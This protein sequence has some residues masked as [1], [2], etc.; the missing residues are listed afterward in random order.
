MPVPR[1]LVLIA[2]LLCA[3]ALAEAL[4]DDLRAEWVRD[5]QDRLA[6]RGLGAATSRGGAEDEAI[7]ELACEARE[8]ARQ[9]LRA[10]ADAGAEADRVAQ[11]AGAL[12]GAPPSDPTAAYLEART[13]LRRAVF[14]HPLLRSLPGLVFV[15][16]EPGALAHMCDQFYG[17]FASGG[18]GLYVLGDP[19]SPHVRDVVGGQLPDGAFLS[20][21]LSYDGRTIAFAFAEVD[22]WR[23]PRFEADARWTYHLWRIATDGADLTRLTEGPYDD[24]DPCWLPDGGLAFISTRRGGYCRC[25][26]RPVPTYTLHRMA[27]DGTGIAALSAHETN[28]WHPAVAADGTLVYTRWDYVDRHTNLAHSLWRCNTDGTGVAALFGNYNAD[29]KPW[30]IWHAQPI[31]GGHEWVGVAGAHHGYAFGSL[32]RIDP[33]EGSDGLGALTRLTP[34]TAFPEA[35]GYPDEA[36]TTPWPLSRELTLASYS[37]R[38]STQTAAHSVSQGIYALLALPDGTSVRELIYRDPAHSSV[39]ALPL[40]PRPT[41]PA[42]PSTAP[43]SPTGRVVLLDARRSA[44]ALPEV[45]PVSLR[46]VQVLP[47]TTVVADDPPI[48]VAKQV[49]ARLLLG[50]VPIEADGSAQFEVPAGVPVYFQTV[51]PDGMAIQT[52]R[53]LTYLEPGEVRTCIGCHEPRETAPPVAS[54]ATALGRGPSPLASGPEGSRP[55]SYPRLVQPVLDRKCLTCHSGAEPAGGVVLTGD[56]ADGDAWSRSYRAL[57]RKSLVH[58]FDSVNGGEWIPRTTAG[59]FGARASR[60]SA[61]LREGHGGV[62]LEG[63]EWERVALWLDLN[64]PFY[65]SYLPRHVE[66]QRAGGAVPEEEL[67]P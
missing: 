26:A 22:P 48:S 46:V 58:W 28:E 30:G 12:R 39:S 42:R 17:G 51:G 66:I 57:A 55:F 7:R 18:G 56:H 52:M 45:A 49:S 60:L 6:E 63:E 25:G 67:L 9:A 47:K 62:V 24:F 16:A 38:W 40:R 41:P 15:K 34:E 31:P 65:G 43:A 23:A 33:W 3:P 21:D 35:E 13:L 50:S 61:L 4:R 36:Y 5:A 29:R 1:A 2:T 54:A 10:I 59:G 11:L 44:S 32:V 37:P 64:V 14:L 8:R 19:E 20:P 27:A 53:S